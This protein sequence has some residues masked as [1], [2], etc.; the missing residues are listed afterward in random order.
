MVDPRGDVSV[1]TRVKVSED[2]GLDAEV[3]L[4]L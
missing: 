1:K 2:K 3:F 4:R